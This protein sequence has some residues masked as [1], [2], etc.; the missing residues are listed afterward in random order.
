MEQQERSSRDGQ[1]ANANGVPRDSMTV[2]S[3]PAAYKASHVIT[4]ANDQVS[5][6]PLPG[7]TGPKELYDRIAYGSE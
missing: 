5:E 7:E 4:G 3:T 2:N 6:L 1:S